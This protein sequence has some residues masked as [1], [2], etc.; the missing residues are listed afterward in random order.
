MGSLFKNGSIN[1]KKRLFLK[2]IVKVAIVPFVFV[3]KLRL[4]VEATHS[5]RLEGLLLVASDK[6]VEDPFL[7]G[8]LALLILLFR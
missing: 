2:N 7:H 3:P 8:C 4:F 1:T 6:H 5:G